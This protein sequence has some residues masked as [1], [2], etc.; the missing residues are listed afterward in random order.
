MEPASHIQ[1]DNPY[2]IKELT[3]ANTTASIAALKPEYNDQQCLEGFGLLYANPSFCQLTDAT[4]PCAI[5]IAKN[6]DVP[7]LLDQKI[8]SFLH[9]TV[10][11]NICQSMSVQFQKQEKALVLQLTAEPQEGLLIITLND[12]TSLSH[13][14]EM[15]ELQNSLMEENAR[16]L[17]T[18]HS[19]LEAEIKRRGR[20]EDKLRRIAGTDHLSGLANR[21]SFLEK[22]TADYRI[23]RRYQ[24]PLSLVM[25][26]L[27]RFKLVN[28]TH[29]H[30][31]GD[32]VI[33]AI[34][35]ICQSLS[36]ME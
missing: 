35:Q 6:D 29:G 9:E 2:S 36:A 20:L 11:K 14:H 3:I 1:L 27:D 5:D 21:R 28:D 10:C 32:T 31:A 33:V 18:I 15:L 17:E 25:L 12:I 24:H 19:A 4:S 30:A 8:L 16:T 34:S 13:N 26:D 22:A 7:F 23:S